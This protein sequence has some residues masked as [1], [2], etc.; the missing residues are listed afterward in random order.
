MTQGGHD[1]NES[2]KAKTLEADLVPLDEQVC[3]QSVGPYAC[4][5]CD[6]CYCDIPGW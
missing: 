5:H 2:E 4:Q 1:M 3:P 6:V